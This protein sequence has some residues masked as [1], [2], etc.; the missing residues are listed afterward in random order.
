M[1]IRETS[2]LPN[3]LLNK[4]AFIPV[5]SRV[6]WKVFNRTVVYLFIIYSRPS[7]SNGEVVDDVEREIDRRPDRP[8]KVNGVLADRQRFEHEIISILFRGRGG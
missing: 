5:A 4:H 7:R 2:S 6:S 1:W 3:N 8:S